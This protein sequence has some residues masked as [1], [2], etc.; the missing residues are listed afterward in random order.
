MLLKL[1]LFLYL[2]T[3]LTK[4]TSKLLVAIATGARFSCW[5]LE[6]FIRGFHVL[7]KMKVPTGLDL[8]LHVRKINEW[9]LCILSCRKQ[10]IRMPLSN[11]QISSCWILKVCFRMIHQIKNAERAANFQ[12]ETDKFLSNDVDVTNIKHRSRNQSS[13][14]RVTG[15]VWM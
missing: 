15:Q 12:K 3:T 14:F 2:L 7:Q 4:Q 8:K 10:E 11:I 9:I 1:V 6:V 13:E 5:S